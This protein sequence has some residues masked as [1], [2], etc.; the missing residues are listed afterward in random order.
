LPTDAVFIERT[1]GH[2]KLLCE[3]MSRAEKETSGAY[4]NDFPLD[5]NK[6]EDKCFGSFWLQQRV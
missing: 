6:V 5:A 1:G 2:S 3:E 4:F